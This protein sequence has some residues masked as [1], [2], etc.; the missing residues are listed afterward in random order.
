MNPNP[1]EASDMPATGPDHKVD[2]V[3]HLDG[4]DAKPPGTLL[5]DG[6]QG[7]PLSILKGSQSTSL[8]FPQSTAVNSQVAQPAFPKPLLAES[9]NPKAVQAQGAVMCALP[10]GLTFVGEAHFP[11]DV[12]ING[13][14]EGKLTAEPDKTIT[15]T[16]S[17]EVKGDLIATNIRIEGR[18]NGDITANG[19]LASFGPKAICHG[20]VTYGTLGIEVGADIEASMKKVAPKSI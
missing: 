16:E 13:S 18:A 19:G 20:Q 3:V 17:G 10:K 5:T 1:T 6:A 7:V 2:Q 4:A 12:Q 9:T 8:H 11:C 15:V 14:M